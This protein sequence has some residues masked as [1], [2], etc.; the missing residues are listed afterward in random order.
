MNQSQQLIKMS[1]CFQLGKAL[2]NKSVFTA[3]LK[4]MTV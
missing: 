4:E 2:L 3:V 1:E